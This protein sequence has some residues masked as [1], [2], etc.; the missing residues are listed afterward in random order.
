ECLQQLEAPHRRIDLPLARADADGVVLALLLVDREILDGLREQVEHST[1]F[2]DR[3]DHVYVAAEPVGL[4][5]V[6]DLLAAADAELVL[7]RDRRPR[8]PSA[9][10]SD[11]SRVA[12]SDSA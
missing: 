1:D 3:V 2:G 4:P 9:A 7:E 8:H 11:Y 12:Q 5:G 10:V 6:D